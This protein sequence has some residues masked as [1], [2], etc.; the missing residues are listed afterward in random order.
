[1]KEESCINCD[2]P[3]TAHLSPDMDIKGVPVCDSCKSM[4]WAVLIDSMPARFLS[5]KGRKAFPDNPSMGKL[6]VI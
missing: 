2:R 5:K 6:G 4:V 1:M 3:A